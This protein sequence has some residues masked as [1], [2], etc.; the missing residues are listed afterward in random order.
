MVLVFLRIILSV[1]LLKV[2]QME[3]WE[4]DSLDLVTEEATEV[5][6]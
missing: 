1:I 5:E 3:E 2:V 4:E 6:Q